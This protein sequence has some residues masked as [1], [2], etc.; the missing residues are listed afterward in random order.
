MF[1]FEVTAAVD[2][3]GSVSVPGNPVELPPTPLLLLFQG[4]VTL[5][6]TGATLTSSQPVTLVQNQQP[7]E[8]LPQFPLDIPTVL[9][10]GATAH[11]LMDLVL[12]QF[13]FNLDTTLTL[14]G[15]GVP[16]PECYPDCTGEGALTVAD[17]GCFQTRFVAGEPYADCTADGLLTVADF[18]C[19]QTRFV[20]GCP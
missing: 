8:P 2:V 17:F 6:P 18:G 16:V 14:S 13:T 11:L 4:T 10:P 20:M 19:F 1:L 15:D 9:P 12:E 5:T 7:G 3:S